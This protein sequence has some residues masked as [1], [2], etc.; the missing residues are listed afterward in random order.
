LGTPEV[1]HPEAHPA[2]IGWLGFEDTL[3]SV[4]IGLL[5]IDSSKRLHINPPSPEEAARLYKDFFGTRQ[6]ELYDPENCEWGMKAALGYVRYMAKALDCGVIVIDPL[7]FLIAGMPTRDRTAAEDQVAAELAALAKSLGVHIHVSHHLKK[8]N[9]EPFE[10][11][12]Q[13]GLDDIRGS[14][15]LTFFASN[16]FGYERD[17]QGDRPDLLRVRVLKCR[18][19]GLTGEAL[20]LK[21]D[22]KTGRY[23]ETTDRWPE[24][25]DKGGFGKS[26]PPAPPPDTGSDY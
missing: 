26:S 8:P 22:H 14:G 15:A 2:K 12:A 7:S 21:Y 18:F 3:R 25:D 1:E 5:S 19:T 13:I 10:E 20:M 16:V 4:K 6:F 11:G 9:G 17:Q 24:K 23:S